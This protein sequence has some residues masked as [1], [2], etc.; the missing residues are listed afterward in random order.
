[1]TFRFVRLSFVLCLCV[2]ILPAVHAAAAQPIHTMPGI[3]SAP[4]TQPHESTVPALLLSDIHFDPFHDPEKAKRLLHAP[5]TQWAAILSGP[6]SSGVQ[7]AFVSLQSACGA[8]GIDTPFPLLHSS[9]EATRAQQSHPAFI[10][11]SG[12]LVAH[13]FDCRFQHEFGRQPQAAYG[14]FVVRTMGFVVHELQAEFPGVPVYISPGNNDTGCGDYRMDAGSAWLRAVAA[15]VAQ[16][17]TPP[18][19]AA[20]F[21]EF[22]ATGSY[23]AVLPAPMHRTRLIVLND[24]LL[25]PKYRTCAGAKDTAA[26]DAELDWLR[27]QLSAARRSG[28][29]VWVMGHI[30]PGVNAY[31]TVRGFRN[32]CGDEEAEMFLASDMLDG[33]LTQYGDIVRLALFGH[34]HMDEMRLIRPEGGAGQDVPARLV[35]SISPVDGNNPSFTVAQVD[36]STAVLEDYRVTVASNQTG[37]GAVWHQEYDYRQTYGQRAFTAAAVAELMQGFS[38]DPK[39]SQIRS[40]EYIRHYFKGNLARE[41][42]PFWP[43]Y[44]CSLENLTARS[45]ANC[46]C[47]DHGGASR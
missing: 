16:G 1:M 15:V 30:P 6:D 26:A 27:S 9:L 17:A 13:D 24:L 12:D 45:Y 18:N 47:T 31:G 32:V 41:L 4:G 5:A 35:S 14:D 33:L 23:S 10:T 43:Q 28:E 29:N 38:A 34:T 20:I 46:V 44:V 2:G 19:R 21:E 36:P 25:S 22:P 11:V 39:A 37:V 3:A 40:Q 7:Q 42:T 8:K